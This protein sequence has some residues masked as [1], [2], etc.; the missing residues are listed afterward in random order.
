G[1]LALFRSRRHTH[2]SNTRR[3]TGPAGWSAFLSAA[4]PGSA[5]PA[6]KHPVIFRALFLRVVLLP[7]SAGTAAL[8]C[9]DLAND[10]AVDAKSFHTHLQP[11]LRFAGRNSF[12]RRRN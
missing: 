12:L 8:V 6:A 5:L 9:L 1:C 11:V 2:D 3:P 4:D 7:A 10:R